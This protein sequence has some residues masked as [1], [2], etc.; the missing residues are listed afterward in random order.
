M[1][2][3]KEIEQGYNEGVA[4][5]NVKEPNSY[6]LTRSVKNI[7]NF[8]WDMEQYLEHLGMP[9]DEA[10]V[11]IDHQFLMKDTKMC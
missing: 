4:H 9:D 7:G 2:L 1:V 11:K 8:V 10:I 3:K 6:D 5:V